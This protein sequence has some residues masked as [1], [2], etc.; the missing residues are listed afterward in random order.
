MYNT[1]ILSLLIIESSGTTPI[2]G[3]P[4]GLF[5]GTQFAYSSFSNAYGSIGSTAVQGVAELALTGVG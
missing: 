1:A 5:A 3:Y 2:T 4:A